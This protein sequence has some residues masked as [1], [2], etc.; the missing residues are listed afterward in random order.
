MATLPKPSNLRRR[1]PQQTGAVVVARP[2]DLERYGAAQARVMRE[3]GNQVAETAEHIVELLGAEKERSDRAAVARNLTSAT[4]RWT[5]ELRD[6]QQQADRKPAG[7]ANA[8]RDDFRGFVDRTVTATP[9]EFQP[10]VREHL[11][12]LGA[13]LVLDADA[14]ERDRFQTAAT[15]DLEAS[16]VAA[17][18][19]IRT[20][21]RQF[22]AMSGAAVTAIRGDP[23]LTET[24]RSELARDVRSRYAVA[25]MRAEI[26][27]GNAQE[28]YAGLKAGN[29]GRHL[30]PQA[31]ERM[32]GETETALRDGQAQAALDMADDAPGDLLSA[33]DAGRL[34]WMTPKQQRVYRNHAETRLG[35][36]AFADHISALTGEPSAVTAG[37][38]PR[39]A[40]QE[41]ASV[42][43]ASTGVPASYVEA[44][45]L[46]ETGGDPDTVNPRNPSVVGL[47]HFD[48]ATAKAV[49]LK[50]RS[51]PQA[52]ATAIAL[53]AN[54]T[55]PALEKALGRRP[56]PWEQYV[57]HQQGIG[58]GPALLSAK[59]GALAVDVLE[60]LYGNRAVAEKAIV[61]NGGHVAIT[62][63]AFV[64]FWRDRYE[65][66]SAKVGQGATAGHPGDRFMSAS[67]RAQLKRTAAALLERASD[68]RRLEMADREGVPLSDAV[69]A[70]RDVRDAHW[71]TVAGQAR[72]DGADLGG[73]AVLAVDFTRRFGSAPAPVIDRLK[74]GMLSSDVEMAASAVEGAFSLVGVD[75]MVWDRLGPD[76]EAFAYRASTLMRNGVPPEEALR[77]ARASAFPDDPGAA[78]EAEA[79]MKAGGEDSLL[80]KARRD[81]ESELD[82]EA[83]DPLIR[84]RVMAGF[85]AIYQSAFIR[86]GDDEAAQAL[87]MDRLRRVWAESEVGGGMMLYRPEDWFGPLGEPGDRDEN[88]SWMR[89]QLAAD[90]A[91]L[92]GHDVAFV[93]PT[94]ALPVGSVSAF[95]DSLGADDRPQIDMDDLLDRVRLEP[96]IAFGESR[97]TGY[98]II[99]D[100]EELRDFRGDADLA[101][102]EDDVPGRI[103]IWVPEW[104]RSPEAAEMR[105]DA[106]R[107]VETARAERQRQL[108]AE[109]EEDSNRAWRLLQGKPFRPAGQDRIDADAERR[110]GGAE[111]QTPMADPPPDA[112]DLE[113][114]AR[115]AEADEAAIG[116]RRG[117]LKHVQGR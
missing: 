33:L 36:M 106:A 39:S 5:L 27:A 100:G 52:S 59:P 56:E 95:F 2:P 90:V 117:V 77:L 46:L 104:H 87:A 51:D 11:E 55:A 65:A 76:H 88:A 70:D 93:G 35:E 12:R 49:G 17:E 111:S 21:P 101:L 86:T 26:D 53:N 103:A 41:W 91:S 50:D 108:D 85:S 15:E 54:R 105:A 13:R 23:Y 42:A 73:M 45:A 82:L 99:I 32:L 97:P 43:E 84:D 28:V 57:A 96:V 112:F 98:R 109:A 10:Y 6:R 63:E 22:E 110:I 25:L 66:A 102:H 44:V 81:A 61:D 4:E 107:K 47:G 14:F 16:F 58:G 68:V 1:L 60:P 89:G 20:D 113:E 114:A 72:L 18:N 40:L 64:G 80:N 19:S 115:A 31:L 30:T 75:A 37:A 24:Q 83:A 78:A 116:R 94:F 92:L 34:R 74:A 9:F 69:K 71:T 48:E 62:A 29:Y 3:A 8:V 7:F 67:H 38:Q 79:R